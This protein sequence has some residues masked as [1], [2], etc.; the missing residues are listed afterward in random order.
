METLTLHDLPDDLIKRI[1]TA[2]FAKGHSIEQEVRELLETHY[3]PQTDVHNRI[4]QRWHTVP[5]T[6]PD[7][8]KRWRATGRQ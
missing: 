7:E 5:R 8:V 4:R 1:Q 6:T 2:A 3:T